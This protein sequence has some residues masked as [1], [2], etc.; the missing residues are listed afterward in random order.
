[1]NTFNIFDIGKTLIIHCDIS[2]LIHYW[3][4]NNEIDKL[5]DGPDIYFQ[6]TN[7]DSIYNFKFLVTCYSSGYC[8]ELTRNGSWKKFIPLALALVD[9]DNKTYLTLS[10]SLTV[11][12]TING[13]DFSTVA[14]IQG[15][16]IS[17]AGY[18]F[19]SNNFCI[20]WAEPYIQRADVLNNSIQIT[21]P[22]NQQK[23]I[24]VVQ[25][26]SSQSNAF[27]QIKGND[28]RSNSATYQFY[29][30]MDTWPE[31]YVTSRFNYLC[32]GFK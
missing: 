11:K 3:N 20:Q 10:G 7:F 27:I 21:L 1:M 12:G 30:L 16:N 19:F 13:T 17:S 9:D 2:N 26:V 23:A 31:S 28:N 6:I 18:I 14:K 32:M 4:T 22:I 5:G 24:I 25:H 15:Q 29:I 8:Y